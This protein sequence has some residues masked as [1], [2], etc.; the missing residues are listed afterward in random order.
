MAA[1]RIR[2]RNGASLRAAR[3]ACSQA[4][5]PL[6]LQLLLGRNSHISSRAEFFLEFSGQQFIQKI[7]LLGVEFSGQQLQKIAVYWSRRPLSGSVSAAIARV[8][9]RAEL[10]RVAR[11]LKRIARCDTRSLL[12]QEW[13]TTISLMMW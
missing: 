10:K 5:G 2:P 3:L 12:R 4:I 8:S 1:A 6:R 7:H 11:E 9:R 13:V